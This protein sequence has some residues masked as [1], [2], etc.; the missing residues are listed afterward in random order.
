MKKINI[1]ITVEAENKALPYNL[2]QFRAQ[3]AETGV[4]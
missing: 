3:G 2:V 4:F 1:F